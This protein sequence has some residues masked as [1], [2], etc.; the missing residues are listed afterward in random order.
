MAEL[1]HYALLLAFLVCWYTVFASFLGARRSSPELIASAYRGV[2]AFLGLLTIAGVALA[3]LLAV[4]DMS[5]E[6]VARY[7]S[8]RLPIFYAIP[9][10][11]AGNAGSLLL[12]VW[13][14]SAYT[15]L[16]IPRHRGTESALVPYA[17]TV[18]MLIGSFFMAM[19][20]FLFQIDPTMT[21]RMVTD[22]FYGI[23]QAVLGITRGG[24]HPMCNPFWRLPFV[25]EEGM[26][27]NPQLQNPGMMFH[28]PAL[29]L[30]YVGMAVPFAFAMA[31]LLSRRVDNEWLL[32]TRRWT[33]T[34]WLFLSLGNLL[35]AWWAYVTLG[36]GGYWAWDPVENAAFIPW[37]LSTAFL[38]SVMIQEKRGML[39][40]WN[41]VLVITAWAMTIFGTYLTRS[42][43]ISSVHAF[44]HNEAFNMSFLAFLLTSTAAAL[45]LLV[46]RLDLLESE[47]QLDSLVSR[48]SAFLFNNVIFVGA[49]FVI[50]FGTMFPLISQ[51]FRGVQV[52]V[53]PA[54]FN[55][56][57][58]PLWVALLLL[59]GVGPLIAWRRAD[60][61]NL[62]RN[63]FYPTAFAILVAAGLPVAG[64]R[65]GYAVGFGALAAFV[66]ATVAQ[67]FYRG[68]RARMEMAKEP[69]PTALAHLISRQ[70][71]R[72]GGYV[73]HLGIVLIV[74]G[75]VGS[76]LYRDEADLTFR[77][78]ESRS[79]GGASYQFVG[80]RQFPE[81]NRD[82]FAASVAITRPGR[83]A[84][85]VEV[86]QEDYHAEQMRWTKPTILH[87][88]WQD[89]YLTLAGFSDDAS[90]V[91]IN[92]KRNPLI[93]WLWLGG[94]VLIVGTAIAMWPDR[95]E[96]QHK[97]RLDAWARGERAD[98]A[99]AEAA[100]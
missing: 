45:Y 52:S 87:S 79:F 2:W 78:G 18:L 29:Y 74:I 67:E 51:L 44:A 98:R 28:P 24:L 59:T 26:G 56:V 94:A 82:V 71:R 96:R 6:Y 99:P 5:I 93:N 84:R 4:R 39:R 43:V 81:V 63:F 38:H 53:G 7:T 11:W 73:V 37:L 75:I 22:P 40:I 61:A 91:T 30:G 1:G 83:P 86:V 49:A 69:A 80:F 3:Y 90:T 47:H 32:L 89:V 9:A 21:P 58:W 33:I 60:A 65:D 76:S 55:R 62:R 66:G 70:N 14:L 35:G 36:W 10:F 85:N 15:A 46:T 31:A 8:S 88:L 23:L 17:V 48:E 25:P 97:R 72:Y 27:L 100:A 12:W 64:V 13:M 95:R 19:I 34:A 41:M 16:L 54:W 68:T 92:V 77:R 57:L 42:G 20:I 50:L